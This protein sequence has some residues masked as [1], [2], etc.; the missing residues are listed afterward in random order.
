MFEALQDGLNSALKTLR[1]QGK[2]SE[3]NM[4]DGLKLVEKS[5]LEADVSFPVVR[6]FHVAGHR[7][8]RRR[9]GARSR[10]TRAS[11]SS[12]SSIRSS[13]NLMG[14][15]DHSMHLQGCERSHRAHDVRPAR[16]RQNDDDRQARPDAQAARPA[17]RCSWPATCSA[18]PLSTS[19]TCS[20]SSSKSRFTR[21]ARTRI[22]SRSANAAVREAKKQRR[23]RRDPRHG[24]PAAHRRRA[25]GS[26]SSGSI[27]RSRRSR[28]T[29]SSTA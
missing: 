16:L 17:S 29:W 7:A 14:P 28:C 2:L 26:S 19:C 24:R 4:R 11:R 1:G 12:A 8:G 13:I 5:L 10:S 22:R 18:R 20:A 25:D 9:E 23:R 15:V 21:T 6:R 27:G 3:S